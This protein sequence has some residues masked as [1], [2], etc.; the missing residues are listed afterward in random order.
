M[1][2]TTI[3]FAVG[4]AALSI[5]VVYS[6]IAS[7]QENFVASPY[8]LS[9][10]GTGTVGPFSLARFHGHGFHG[11]LGLGFY[12]PL[13]GGY[14]GGYYDQLQSGTRTEPN[15]TCVWSGYEWNCYNF[16]N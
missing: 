1:R 14:Y 5:L 3:M 12:G 8:L 11:G 13:Y 16:R 4:L 9:T 2:K 15:R 10:S 7:A 6:G